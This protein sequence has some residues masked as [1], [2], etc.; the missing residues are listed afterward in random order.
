MN[1]AYA[2]FQS[3]ICDIQ[4]LGCIYSQTLNQYSL[5]CEELKDILRAQIVYA[6]SAMDCY[7]HEIVKIGIIHSYLG[8]RTPTE[9]WKGT[10]I[11]L[12]QVRNLVNIEKRTDLSYFQK[13]PL[14]T[15][16]LNQIVEPILKT[17]SFQHPDKIKDALSY[18]W[19]EPHKMQS[20]T[21]VINYNLIGNN[22]NEK[23]KYL[24]QK[25]QLI[26]TR[27]NKIVHEA[28]RDITTGDKCAICKNEVDDIILF[29]EK[30]VTAIH[31]KII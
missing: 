4:K 1:N 3:S 31:S 28:D 21:T 5:L 16:Q 22:S 10:C 13:T 12:H 2:H 27:R 20:I 17:M 26:V 11:S 19:E 30:F 24:E 29:I 8:L 23:T 15:Q 9:K 14:I 25:L 6:V 18:I 7:I